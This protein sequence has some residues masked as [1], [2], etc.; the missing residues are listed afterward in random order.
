MHCVY[1]EWHSTGKWWGFHRTALL[2]EKVEMTRIM[3]TVSKERTWWKM[4]LT[5]IQMSA[6]SVIVVWFHVR[7]VSSHDFVAMYL[8]SMSKDFKTVLDH[9]S[10]STKVT[11]AVIFLLLDP[12]L[13]CCQ[14]DKKLNPKPNSTASPVK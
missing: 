2:E 4:W 10:Q 1:C 14:M 12:Q 6:M 5:L 11:K 8:Q 9:Q 7:G 13:F 3:L